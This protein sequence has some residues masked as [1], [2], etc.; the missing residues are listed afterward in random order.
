VKSSCEE[1]N[2]PSGYWQF[3]K[4]LSDWKLFKKG[5]AKWRCLLVTTAINAH[6]GDGGWKGYLCA[7]ATRWSL[8]QIEFHYWTVNFTI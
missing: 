5:S 8:K 2:E 6:L 7:K 3:L 1:G 4:Q